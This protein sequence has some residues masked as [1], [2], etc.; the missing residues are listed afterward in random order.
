MALANFFSFAY[1]EIQNFPALLLWIHIPSPWAPE[2]SVL[3][4]CSLVIRVG[5]GIALLSTL[6]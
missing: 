1:S 2:D 4:G 6:S 3:S 5:Y